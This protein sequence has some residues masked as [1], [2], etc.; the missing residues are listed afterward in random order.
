MDNKSETVTTKGDANSTPDAAPVAIKDLDGKV[1]FSIPMLGGFAAWLHTTSGIFAIIA[2]MI[3]LL[4]IIFVPNFMKKKKKQTKDPN[5]QSKHAA[6]ADQ[7]NATVAPDSATP[8]SVQTSDTSAD[9][10]EPDTTVSETATTATPEPTTV[11][12]LESSE[13]VPAHAKHGKAN[14]NS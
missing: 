12:T 7:A 13:P 3:G 14:D 4:F 10:Q 5:Y 9:S 11:T 6:A 8:T 2:Y 1:I